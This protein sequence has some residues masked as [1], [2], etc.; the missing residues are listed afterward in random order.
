LH[1]N[2]ASLGPLR[3][4]LRRSDLR[5]QSARANRFNY[6]AMLLLHAP[7]QLFRAKR[8]RVG[9]LLVIRGAPVQ[10]SSLLIYHGI[11]DGMIRPAIFSLH[12]EDVLSHFDV[13]I[14]ARAH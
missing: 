12:V 7:P 8:H 14:E 6:R 1:L 2:T 13:R 9:T 3:R 11:N 5:V 4:W 10:N